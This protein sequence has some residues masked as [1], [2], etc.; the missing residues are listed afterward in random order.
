[1]R[2]EAGR[3]NGA[4]DLL[5][6]YF[7]PIALTSVIDKKVLLLELDGRIGVS[8]LT[9][10]AGSGI[11][12]DERRESAEQERPVLHGCRLPNASHNHPAINVASA[13]R[14]PVNSARRF[15]SVP[16]ET[17]NESRLARALRATR[18]LLSSRTCKQ[19]LAS[20]VY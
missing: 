20:R 16:V 17:I 6:G 8:P 11:A 7:R 4:D 13:V 18:L 19:G 5:A 15:G 12:D 3:R 10:V 14:N 2:V 1:M 9:E